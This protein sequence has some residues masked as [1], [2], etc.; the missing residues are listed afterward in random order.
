MYDTVIAEN[1]YLS[2]QRM[3]PFLYHV[4]HFNYFLVIFNFFIVGEVIALNID[5][6]VC[7][8]NHVNYIER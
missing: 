7:Y 4:Q 2:N 3:K 6:Q 5:N 1:M 8:E